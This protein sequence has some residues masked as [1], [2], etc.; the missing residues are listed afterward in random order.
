MELGPKFVP[1]AGITKD[2]LRRV[3]LGVERFAFGRRWQKEVERKQRVVEVEG[4]YPCVNN[5]DGV[6]N[7]ED[8]RP[9][10]TLDEDY[11]ELKKIATT[12]RQGPPMEEKDENGLRR[13]KGN[14]IKLYEAARKYQIVDVCG[15]KLTV[16]ER[17]SIKQL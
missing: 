6:D 2:V 16:K 1:R 8:S 4:R 11:L 5:N 13:L 7:S 17:E 12:D 9:V 10:R 14:I 3:E 15:R